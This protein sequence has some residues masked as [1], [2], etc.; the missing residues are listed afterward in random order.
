MQELWASFSGGVES[1]TLCLLFGH[2]CRGVF[3]DAGWE[4][5]VMYERIT[6]VEETIRRR[7]PT[8]CIERVRA[9][10]A[11]GT[12]TNN[13]LDYIRLRKFYPSALARYC[14][15]IFKI[16]PIDR[17]LS[18]RGKVELMIGLNYEERDSRE[19]N[20]G[21]L[22]N[23]TYSYPLIDMKLTREACIAILKEHD[24]EPRF[25]PYMARGGCVGCHFKRK[26]EYA[27]MA[28]H[29]P[30]EF[31]QVADVEEAIQDRRGTF[32][33]VRDGIPNMRRF[34]E[35]KRREHESQGQLFP[36]QMADDAIPPPSACGVFCHR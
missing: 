19:G 6:H 16:E 14:T 30:A 26:S 10:N 35:A 11:D 24:L 36:L 21:L 8:F 4:H 28:V 23:V 3:A 7:H 18:S 1:T 15:R 9:E 25:P 13:L 29:S 5:A 2:R 32:Y 27:A 20:H 12:G 34:G 22:A 31:D 17:F 33:A